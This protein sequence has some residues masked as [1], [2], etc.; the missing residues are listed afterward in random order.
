MCKGLGVRMRWQGS[1]LCCTQPQGSATMRALLQETDAG[2]THDDMFGKSISHEFQYGN[3]RRC[4][5]AAQCNE[6]NTKLVGGAHAVLNGTAGFCAGQRASALTGPLCRLQCSARP[7]GWWR[8][9][10]C[11][12][13]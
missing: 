12:P 9:S 3:E 1:C 5:N 13:T 6:A 10:C 8:S 7:T 2:R 11:W 4:V